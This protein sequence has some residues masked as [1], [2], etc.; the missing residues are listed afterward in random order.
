MECGELIGRVMSV[1]GCLV[2]IATSL[3]AGAAEDATRSSE[4]FT[5]TYATDPDNHDA[6]DLTDSD[7]NGTPDVVDRVLSEYEAA[8]TFLV[9]DLGFR[10]PPNDGDYPL[11]VARAAGSGYTRSMPGGIG[12]SKPSYTVIPPYLIRSEL[13]DPTVATFAV[14]EYMHAIQNGY[15]SGTDVWFKEASAS[16]VEDVYRDDADRNHFKAAEFLR[17]P[18]QPLTSTA[19]IHEYGAFL[20]IEFLAQRYGGGSSAAIVLVRE[21]WEAMSV[22][23]VGGD[24]LS[25]IAALGRWM[26]DRGV[27]WPDAWREFMLWNRQLVHYEEGSGYRAATRDK[28]WPRPLRVTEVSSE[29]CRLTTDNGSRLPALSGDYVKLRPGA[30]VPAGSGI[31]TASGP[32]GAVGTY[33]IRHRDGG[34]TEGFLAFDDAGLATLEVPFDAASIKNLLL[35][36]GNGI[37]GASQSTVAYSLRIPGRSTTDVE[38]RV[39]GSTTVG[40]ALRLSGTV[41]CRGLPA[42]FAAIRITAV[43]ADGTSSFAVTTTDED[44]GFGALVSPD[45]RTTYSVE[46]IDPL[47]ASTNPDQRTVEVRVRVT[48]SLEPEGVSA[49]QPVRVTGSVYPAHAGAPLVVEFRRPDRDWRLGSETFVA[50]DGT[51]DALLPLPAKGVWEVRSRVTATL[52]DDHL[53]NQSVTRLVVVRSPG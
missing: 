47:L 20:F 7:G 39:A 14:H 18:R 32:A 53:V 40:E 34:I 28:G 27:A 13:P 45:Q 31:L 9:D 22:A 3:P 49:N 46:L 16:W 5:I 2:L 42:P 29:S 38:L 25:A 11:Y 15:D 33:V 51:Y 10:P 30:D 37:P 4:N 52:D 6:P 48:I 21:A 19:G 17:E 44:G 8:R 1:V 24:G 12:D 50:G 35:G 36:L 26:S 41:T 23:E 43:G